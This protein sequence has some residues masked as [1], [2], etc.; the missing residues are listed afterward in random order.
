MDGKSFLD[1]LS[2]LQESLRK[3]LETKL[4]YYGLLAFEKAARLVTSLLGNAVALVLLFI[5]L[6]FLSGAGALYLGRVLGSLEYGLLAA[7]GFYLLLALIF[8]GFRRK[9]FGSCVVRHLA[10]LFFHG[11]E[12]GPDTPHP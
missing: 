9:I 3:Y 2:G 12:K 8:Y 1:H 7:G 11:E 10:E 4:S 5:G 6:V